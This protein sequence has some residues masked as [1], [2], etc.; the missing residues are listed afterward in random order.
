MAFLMQ[1]MSQLKEGDYLKHNTKIKK[2][3]LHFLALSPSHL[4]EH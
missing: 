4:N 1:E 3:N 2:E